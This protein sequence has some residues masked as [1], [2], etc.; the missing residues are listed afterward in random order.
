MDTDRPALNHGVGFNARGGVT[1]NAYTAYDLPGR[2]LFLT[3]SAK[4][5]GRAKENGSDVAD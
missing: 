1:E 3:L 2:D 5:R 4:F